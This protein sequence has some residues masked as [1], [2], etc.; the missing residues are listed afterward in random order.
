MRSFL[1]IALVPALLAAGCVGAPSDLEAAS[2]Q[3]STAIAPVATQVPF[4]WDGSITP[5]VAACPVVTCAGVQLTGF[6]KPL[7]PKGN[8]TG[9]SLT[10][11]WDAAVPT[12]EELRLGVSW[13]EDSYES[14]E[15]ASP[16]VLELHDV[17]IARSKDPYVWVWIPG[18]DPMGLVAVGTPQDFHVEG[19]VEELRA[20]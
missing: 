12:M 13:G 4:S 6:Y 11:T 10:M 20:P 19:T 7:A 1:A 18:Q 5:A 17:D 9:L 3:A 16:L 2:T 15:G 8:V 14:V